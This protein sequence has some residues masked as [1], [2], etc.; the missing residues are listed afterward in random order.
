MCETNLESD[1]SWLCE[2]T[3][4]IIVVFIEYYNYVSIAFDYFV[5]LPVTRGELLQVF[6]K[7]ERKATGLLTPDN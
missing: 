5:K 7:F 6:I 1:K 4:K 2:L 3:V